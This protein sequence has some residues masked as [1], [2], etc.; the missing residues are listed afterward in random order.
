MQVWREGLGLILLITA[1]LL[2]SN[3]DLLKQDGR[4]CSKYCQAAE[5]INHPRGTLTNK[6]SV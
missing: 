5:C 3:K 2:D 1:P 4:S 6:F